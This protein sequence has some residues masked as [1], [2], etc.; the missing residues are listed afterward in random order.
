MIMKIFLHIGKKSEWSKVYVN[1][2]G[3]F[4]IHL[5]GGGLRVG[6]TPG[7]FYYFYSHLSL[8]TVFPALLQKNVF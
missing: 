4:Q 1:N 6:A 5:G 7:K 8:E 3:L 2:C